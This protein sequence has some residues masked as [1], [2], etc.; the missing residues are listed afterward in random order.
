MTDGPASLT[1]REREILALVATGV[2]NQR[3][4]RD[5]GISV[6][7]VKAHLRNIF[8][9]L[10]V[11]SRTEATTLAIQ[12]GLVNVVPGSLAGAPAGTPDGAPEAA[13]VGLA[14]ETS[15]A[16]GAPQERI[17]IRWRLTSGQVV[18]LA[19][20]LLLAVAFVIWGGRAPARSAAVNRFAD[21]PAA[22]GDGEIGSPAGR[23]TQ[24]TALSRPRARFAQAALDGA[25]YVISGVNE[26]GCTAAVERYDVTADVWAPR[27]DKPTPVANVGAAV[28][29]GRIYV[30]G[31]YDADGRARDVLEVYDPVTDAWSTAA[32]LPVGLYAYAV[33][34]YGE[35]FYV[36][37]GYD[38][39]AYVDTVYYYDVTRDAWDGVGRLASPRAFAAAATAGGAIYVVGG[40]DGERE[41]DSC[42][43]FLPAEAAAGQ[44]PWRTHAALG[45]TRAGHALVA[46]GGNLY[47]VG[48][49]WGGSLT[50]NERYDLAHDLWS[51]FES[52]HLG[53]WRTLGLSAISGADGTRLY[54]IGGWSG[55]LLSGVEVY[56]AEYRLYLP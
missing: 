42:V 49:G 23:W 21:L 52:P 32:A 48:G 29:G 8:G 9:K 18:T 22:A 2:T 54:A 6:N 46:S 34:P 3:I 33:A 15:A 4:A 1:D 45:A 24:R 20:A 53:E 28:V 41:L 55:R 50:A 12:M 37:G 40:T 31:G 16:S 35:G 10:G 5:M 17:A 26:E 30:P 11:A 56:Q 13:A 38:G 19:A 27:A 25:I 7:T 43:S 36:F 44:D 47:A 14:R 51:T 39:S